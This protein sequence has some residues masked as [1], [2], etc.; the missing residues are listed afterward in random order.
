MGVGLQYYFI[1]RGVS[2]ICVPCL[3]KLYVLEIYLIYLGSDPFLLFEV[4]KMCHHFVE[5]MC[6]VSRML[7][8]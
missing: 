8:I 3:P 1:N 4:F 2:F 7:S 6:L 5:I